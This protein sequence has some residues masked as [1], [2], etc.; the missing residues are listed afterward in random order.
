MRADRRFGFGGEM[1]VVEIVV[2]IK[3]WDCVHG[4]VMCCVTNLLSIIIAWFHKALN[5]ASDH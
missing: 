5:M 2:M 3:G 4:I 1:L